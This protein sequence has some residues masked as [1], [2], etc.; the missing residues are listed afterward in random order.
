MMIKKTDRVEIYTK[1]NCSFCT[2]AK[3]HLSSIDGLIFHELKLNVDFAPEQIKD[4]LGIPHDQKIT[5]PQIFVNG[6]SIGGYE[7]MMRT[8]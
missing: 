6:K 5:M 2:R 1:E 8:G 3:A 4:R 7:D